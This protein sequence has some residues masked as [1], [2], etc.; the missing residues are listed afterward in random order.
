MSEKLLTIREV[1]HLLEISEKEVVDLAEQGKIPA[2][3]VGGLYLR[4]KKDQI[5]EIRHRF[6]PDSAAARMKYT[7]F[8]RARDFLVYNDFYIVSAT[9]ILAIVYIIF[10][11][12]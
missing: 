4:F 10:K 2:Y 5:D 11:G 12:I 8:E 1:S 6:V 7:P 3:K 9:V